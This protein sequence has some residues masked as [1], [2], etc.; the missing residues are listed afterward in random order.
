MEDVPERTPPPLKLVMAGQVWVPAGPAPDRVTQGSPSA[1]ATEIYVGMGGR[2][3]A[4]HWMCGPGRWRVA[5]DET[6]Y[7]RI[8]SGCG[9][10]HGPDGA[11]PLCAG[12]EIVVPR[13]FVGEWEVTETM[14]K[15]YVCLLP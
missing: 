14:T 3:C 6:E 9:V 10:I 12:D 8:I 2:L 13:G 15:T 11:L 1:T 4:G 7:C 5:Y